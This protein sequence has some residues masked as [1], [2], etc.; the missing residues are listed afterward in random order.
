MYIYVQ[1]QQKMMAEHYET[2][3]G[4]VEYCHHYWMTPV[5]TM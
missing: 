4:V 2:Q 3:N 5:H 1:M